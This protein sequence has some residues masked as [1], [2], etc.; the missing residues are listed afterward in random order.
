MLISHEHKF[1]FLKTHKTASTSTEAALEWMC[2][3]DG[4]VP[5]HEQ[6]EMKSDRGYISGRMGGQR[7]TDF[8]PT[9]AR[10]LAVQRKVGKPVFEEYTK[11]YT[12]RNP[13][14]KVVSWFWHV[15]PDEVAKTVAQDFKEAQTLF[16]T[17]LQ[18]RPVLPN[19]LGVYRLPSGVFPARHIRFER[20]REDLDAFVSELGHDSSRI[21]IPRWKSGSRMHKDRSFEEYYTKPTR[22]IVRRAFAF[23]FENFGY[24]P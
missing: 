19:D 7:K 8:I 2:S 20:L 13:Y 9:H 4:H 12:I 21:E 6:A 16:G 14:D 24:K 3:P 5:A 18:M 15:M 10:A 22:D 1:I 17:W 11:L 23:D